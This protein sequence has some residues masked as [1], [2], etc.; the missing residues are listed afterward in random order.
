MKILVDENVLKA[1]AEMFANL[2]NYW[3]VSTWEMGLPISEQLMMADAKKEYEMKVLGVD[4]QTYGEYKNVA[5]VLAKWENFDGETVKRLRRLAAVGASSPSEEEFDITISKE[6]AYD[7]YLGCDRE[8]GLKIRSLMVSAKDQSLEYEKGVREQ[9]NGDLAAQLGKNK[10]EY[11]AKAQDYVEELRAATQRFQESE[12]GKTMAEAITNSAAT[13]PVQEYV[14]ELKKIADA[15]EANTDTA[16][17]AES[18]GNTTEK[19][20]TFR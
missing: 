16:N 1:N 20:P 18:Y 4:E 11:A 17:A 7:R 19:G 2:A 8:S 5:K 12:A 10:E 9:Y 15:A 13:G 3:D 14:E 6:E